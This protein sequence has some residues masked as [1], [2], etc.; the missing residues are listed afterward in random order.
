MAEDRS[1]EDA[2]QE[3]VAKSLL[4]LSDREKLSKALFPD[5]HTK[6]V[7]LLGIT[8]QLRPVPL[9]VAKQLETALMPVSMKLANELAKT[10]ADVGPLVISA[11]SKAGRILATYYNWQ[12]VQKGLDEEDLSVTE[13]Q[14]LASVQAQ[15]NG[16]N[17]FLLGPLRVILKVNQLHEI[18][19]RK[20]QSI[21]SMQ[22]FLPSGT[23]ASTN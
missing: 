2:L 13:L 1:L 23:A 6:E 19:A 11:L 5:T 14:M 8:R 3:D 17:D 9:K 21:M 15:L 4:Q 12:D 16:E 7:E 10:E 18:I 22:E 20:F